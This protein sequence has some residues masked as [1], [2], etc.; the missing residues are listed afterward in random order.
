MYNKLE[1][2]SKAEVDSLIAG[3][4]ADLSDYYTKVEVD[5]LISAIPETDLTNYYDK[6]ETYNKSEV[7]TKI[8]DIPAT[9]LSTTIIKLK[10][11]I[12]LKL[13]LR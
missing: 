13:I 3:G 12:K 9:D 11:I 10:H 6:T 7:D 5:N 1:S 2:Y 4:G 8:A